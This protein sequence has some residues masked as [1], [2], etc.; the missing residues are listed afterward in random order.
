MTH[1]LLPPLCFCL[2]CYFVAAASVAWAQYEVEAESPVWVRG[3]LDVRIAGGSKAPSW[4][5]RGS[6]KLRYGGRATATAF[7]HVTR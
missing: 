4:T 2:L 1:R 6:G 5:D 7:E 3:L